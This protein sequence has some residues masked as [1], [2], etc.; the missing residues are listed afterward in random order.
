MK[1]NEKLQLIYGIKT[2][3]KSVLMSY[4]VP[5]E[6]LYE[7]ADYPE[8]IRNLVIVTNPFDLQWIKRKD[9]I[10]E[11]TTQ[12]YINRE[13][14]TAHYEKYKYRY[15]D[16][17]V[18]GDFLYYERHKIIECEPTDSFTI[19]Y[20]PY[21]Q[22]GNTAQMKSDNGIMYDI[23]VP[24]YGVI[25]VAGPASGHCLYCDAT[26]DLG[27]WFI[28]Y[29][30]KPTRYD[31][32]KADK[33]VTSLGATRNVIE[34]HVHG[35]PELTSIGYFASSNS[36]ANDSKTE[37]IR[38][39]DSPNVNLGY[40]TFWYAGKLRELEM[41]G[42]GIM[43]RNSNSGNTFKNCLEL[44]KV[45]FTSP[46]VNM[47]G[48]GSD[49]FFNN[50]PVLEEIYGLDHTSSADITTFFY[51]CPSIRYC[52]ISNFGFGI[53]KTT[54]DRTVNAT[55]FYS[56]IPISD[57]WEES[58]M[59]YTFQNAQ[60][61]ITGKNRIVNVPQWMYDKMD[62]HNLIALMTEKGYTITLNDSINY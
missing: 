59:V 55:K 40:N 34:M 28:Q 38:I 17:Y 22:S 26:N 30:T 5:E 37:I 42:N 9:H 18:K 48:L 61:N 11:E 60:E 44:K 25:S 49:A 29:N 21:S 20:L 31:Y 15:D 51:N 4:D 36:T 12:V 39:Y 13:K 50:C 16:I 32:I 8:I 57:C 62:E 23:S 43:F 35:S 6:D 10:L 47:T 2:D 58:D 41:D 7:L 1:F 56:I 45:N 24:S 52:R 33:N 14:V 3:M 53:G 54:S 19:T 27:Q 46:T